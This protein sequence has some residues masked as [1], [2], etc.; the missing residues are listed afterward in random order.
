M[1]SPCVMNQV[2]TYTLWNRVGR[3]KSSDLNQWFFFSKKKSNKSQK[4][5]FFKEYFPK[6]SMPREIYLKIY[7][8]KV[9]SFP[10]ILQI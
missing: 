9:G 1:G 3:F 10:K 7:V 2:Y 4:M 6:Y 8:N 5:D